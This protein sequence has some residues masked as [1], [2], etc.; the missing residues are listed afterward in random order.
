MPIVTMTNVGSLTFMIVVPSGSCSG[1]GSGSAVRI[2]VV[3]IFT[4]AWL[5][6]T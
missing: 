3:A 1:S 4:S 2:A 6:F 5:L